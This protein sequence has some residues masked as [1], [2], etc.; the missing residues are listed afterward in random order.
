MEVLMK[1]TIILILICSLSL[2]LAGSKATVSGTI[3]DQ[4]GN[5]F[6]KANILVYSLVTN[7]VVKNIP[8]TDK[9]YKV[10]FNENGV[11]EIRFS[12]PYHLAH[13]VTVFVKENLN[14]K[15]NIK[16]TPFKVRD[17]FDDLQV[18][19]KSEKQGNVKLL[20]QKGTNGKY[21]ATFKS[22]EKKINYQLLG[23]EATGHS[24][25][26]TEGEFTGPDDAGDYYST[27]G[28]DNGNYHFVFNPAL[29]PE[30]RNEKE[31]KFLDENSEFAILNHLKNK[32]DF[33]MNDYYKKLSAFV[34]SGKKRKDFKYDTNELQEIL[35]KYINSDNSEIKKLGLAFYLN[36]ESIIGKRNKNNREKYFSL[37]KPESDLWSLTPFVFVYNR[38]VNNN[39]E[40][41]K[42]YKEFYAKNKNQEIKAQ[43]LSVNY[44]MAKFSGKKEEMK[45]IRKLLKE[46]YSKSRTFKFFEKRF[47]ENPAISVGKTLPKFSVNEISDES[48]V[49]TNESFKGKVL[50][51]D[52]W[53]TWCGPC[54]SEL[55]HLHKAY[56]KFKDKGLVILSLSF[57]RSPDKVEKFRKG[58]WKMPW[59][60]AFIKDGFSNKIASDFE[61]VGIPKPILVDRNGKIIEL[62]R[63]IRGEKLLKTLEKYFN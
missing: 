60:N 28:S 14:Q 9:N 39:P 44:E 20:M 8:V 24:V 10:D 47:P 40:L 29:L 17:N 50:L 27:I 42:Y 51:L 53:A 15:V 16:M 38:N 5:Q 36:A 1:K 19:F 61:V 4:D 43:R 31:V 12:A 32:V 56:E 18:I 23:L 6:K 13:S 52:F 34:A 30:K 46:K 57:D 55:P 33:Y 2:L 26:G 54:K 21:S 62:S 25:N 49:Y 37:V 7:K 11:Y 59:C 41:K 22:D 3:T 63:N 58:K 35:N 45:N 48:K